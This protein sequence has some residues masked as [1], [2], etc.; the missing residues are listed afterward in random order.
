MSA[1]QPGYGPGVRILQG[2]SLFISGAFAATALLLKA[3]AAAPE[4]Q[5]PTPALAPFGIAQ[6]VP[7][8][9]SR[10]VGSPDPPMPY[11]IRRVF[12]KLQFTNLVDMCS[13]PGTQRL[14]IGEQAGRI[15]S[16]VPG[17]EAKA[18]VF[19]DLN[20]AIAGVN[21]LY[22]MAFH[23]GF[24]TNR[25]VYL[26]YVLK[27][28]LPD[29]SRVSRFSVTKSDP[30]QI[31]AG[32]EKIILTWLSG[33][34]N[35]GCLKFGL[36]GY[37]Y[38]S[39]GDGAGPDPPDPL[40]TGQDISDLLSSILRI[41]VDHPQ[42]G[43]DYGIPTDNP[44]VGQPGV[45]PEVWA[46]GLRNPWRMSIDR[47][48]GALWVGDVGWELWEM[49]Y[50]IERG[51]NY[52]WSIVEGPQ[53]I[54]PDWKRGPTP[55]LPPV[56]AHPHS[57]AASI[58]G[59]VVYYGK[60]LPELAGAYLYGDWVT[61]K[62][63]GLRSQAGKLVSLT[64]LAN[65]TLQVVC[66]AEDKAGELFVVDYGGGIYQLQRN[67]TS[68]AQ[69]AF[70]RK[71]SQSGLFASTKEHRLAPGVLPFAVNT[72]MW[73]DGALA[74]R[75]IGLPGNSSIETG[76]TNVW[77]Y[78]SKNEWRY[79]TNAVLGKTLAVKMRQGQPE[80]LRRL[81]TQL[82]HYDGLRWHAY[83]YRW[84]EEQTD[85]TLVD[86]AGDELL[87][88]IEDPAAPG[89]RRPQTWR[90]HSRA[91]CLR[92]HNPWVNVAL[93]FTAPQLNRTVRYCADSPVLDQAISP[94][95][96]AAGFSRP[97]VLANQLRTLS[98][99]AFFDQSLDERAGPKLT[100][101]YDASA[102]LNQRARSWLHVNC[103]H[104][105]REGAGGSVV[106]HF[107]YDTPLGDMK[108]LNQAPSQG[109]LGLANAHVITPGNPS[110]S[111]L[112]YRISTSGQGRMPLIGSRRFDPGGVRL[113]HDWFAQL[114]AGSTNGQVRRSVPPHAEEDSALEA[115]RES[116]SHGRSQVHALDH[117]LTTP[118]SA[119]ALFSVICERSETLPAEA[120]ETIAHHQLFQVRDLFEPFL[121]ERLRPKKLGS[122]IKPEA[123]LA[124]KA[125]AARGRALFFREGVQC[126][127]CHRVQGE[128]RD[129]GP[130][131]SQIGRKYSRAQLL[132][133]ILF[134]SKSIEPAYVSY[135]VETRDGES[136]SGLL[137]SRTSEEVVLKDTSLNQLHVPA[138]KIKALQPLQ[139]SAMP[140]G[141]LQSL[142]AQDAADLIEFL[143]SLK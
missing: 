21:D 86:A 103:S 124:L 88:E 126:A 96:Q 51:G 11:Q 83:T 43:K 77:I 113:I 25:Y 137:V 28:G 111:V 42:S 90:F 24:E 79:P 89:G 141:L 118:S 19:F 72:P 57:E 125:D 7:W 120:L 97:G 110:S 38:V 132:E 109:T 46:Y 102:D 8:T 117:L 129:F 94:L 45:R 36:D 98:H 59:G 32:S 69:G 17:P 92:C 62:I 53:S 48:T 20:K 22:G 76:A 134:P 37:L 81:E 78:Q 75:F 68:V 135:Q 4:G 70:P 10:V 64:E 130:D 58:T 44:F 41:D 74:E 54:H 40:Q 5:H 85:A 107:D 71:L 31:E 136:Y 18:E 116:D 138:A 65:S 52:G 14:F 100:D 34:H 95:G 63:W 122:S 66:F 15:Y 35:G 121:P 16:F 128:G 84:N 142:T 82:L 50:R 131:L 55:I 47:R 133:Q 3:H 101:P 143:S 6:R 1:R 29:G 33:G 108:A 119:L 80:S 30:P 112:F 73:A 61:G 9:T 106:S 104:C 127:N 140:E 67:D 114:P 123:I 91:E 49:I 23:P 87:L 56:K 26:C 93:A 27:D 12:P 105:H 99:L 60:E 115:L 13:A 39:T 139:L 2:A